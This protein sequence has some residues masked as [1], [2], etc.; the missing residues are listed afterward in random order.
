M[1]RTVQDQPRL[2][3]VLYWLGRVYYARGDKTVAADYAEQSLAI[4]DSMGDE[5]L[6]ALPT[7]LLG[8]YYSLQ[9]NV[10]RASELLARNVEQ[11]KHIGDAAEE[12]TAAGFAGLSFSWKGDFERGL[13]DLN[14]S[15]TLAQ[16]L[17]NPFAEAA[18]YFYRGVLHVQRGAWPEGI[19]DFI[20]AVEIAETMVDSFRIYVS[21]VW[22]SEA[23][24][25]SGHP[26]RAR[27][28][29][30]YAI[31]FAEKVGTKFALS[32]AKRN[33]ASA[34]CS[35]VLLHQASHLIYEFSQGRSFVID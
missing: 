4:A 10:I 7:N 12:A 18:A 17:Q 6:A 28:M 33:L 5:T 14:R 34:L 30:E 21:N 22:I 2:A 8:R 31:G 29:L 27:Q 11:M 3:Q 1:A 19:D 24:V 20:G 16:Q 35:M 26:E 9:E 32:N 25:E 15:L 13:P 23:L